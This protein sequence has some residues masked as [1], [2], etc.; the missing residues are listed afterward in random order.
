MRESDT[1]IVRMPIIC[2]EKPLG[3]RKHCRNNHSPRVCIFTL[4]PPLMPAKPTRPDDAVPAPC[5]KCTAILEQ[6][7]T[8]RTR[9]FPQAGSTRKYSHWASAPGIHPL[10]TAA[11]APS[12]Y[13]KRCFIAPFDRSTRSLYCL[14]SARHSD[15]G[16]ALRGRAS[17][18]GEMRGCGVS[19]PSVRVVSRVFRA[20]THRNRCQSP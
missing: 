8:V 5:T 6:P 2:S 7:P 11:C 9:Y 19:G 13:W 10:S 17:R 16:M 14:R 4:H 20:A 3:K 12:P 15:Q 18:T 1:L